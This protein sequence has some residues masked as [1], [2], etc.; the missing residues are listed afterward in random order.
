MTPSDRLID[1]DSKVSPPYVFPKNMLSWVALVPPAEL[2]SVLLQHP[3]IADS[4][5]IAVDSVEEATE[6]P[7]YVGE[8]YLNL[9]WLTTK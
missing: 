8:L 6:L 5:V 9:K 7:R 3:E 4:G 2:E 1:R